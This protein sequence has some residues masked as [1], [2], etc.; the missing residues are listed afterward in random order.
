MSLHDIWRGDVMPLSGVA[1]AIGRNTFDPPSPMVPVF[2]IHARELDLYGKTLTD[3]DP[4]TV[5]SVSG[6][7]AFDG[8]RNRL[9]FNPSNSGAAAVCTAV[10][11]D[12]YNTVSGILGNLII[13]VVLPL[14]LRTSS[15]PEDFTLDGL[16]DIIVWASGT[17]EI[18][19][20]FSVD[21]RVGNARF[22]GRHWLEHS[23]AAGSFAEVPGS[24]SFT[25]MRNN[26]TGRDTTLC[27]VILEGVS[28]GDKFRVMGG[29]E[30]SS[31]PP[32]FG[33]AIEP[34]GG[35]LTL[36]KVA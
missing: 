23:S 15:S 17:Y 36:I 11:I 27:T 8:I 2:D 3:D 13:P 22:S 5:T 34:D 20:R 33:P 6:I 26:S 35:G 12:T 32:P 18:T 14:E 31:D 16:G 9:I 21:S 24:R 7:L 28:A 1:V 30:D 29:T 25:F 19:Y 10:Y 4:P